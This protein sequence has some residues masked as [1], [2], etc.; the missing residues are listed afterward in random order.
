MK[1]YNKLV[2]DRI[3]E[4]MRANGARPKARILA[5][6]DQYKSALLE[7]LVEEAKET[8]E[9]KG[10]LTGLVKEIGDVT[11]VISAIVEAYKLD[12][13]TIEDVREERLKSRGGFGMRIFLESEE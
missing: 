9:A 3:P 11:E 4:I 5:D 12:W 7:K 6:D 8:L 1:I 13:D 10:D 2:R